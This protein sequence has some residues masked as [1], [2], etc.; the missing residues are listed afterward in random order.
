M[1]NIKTFVFN[2]FQEN[3]YV[4]SDDRNEAV[5]IDCGA[6]FNEE[7][8]ELTDYI[9]KNNL[10][11][12]HLLSTHGHIDHNFG[13]NTIADY[14]NVRPE[15]HKAD[16]G[17]M[18][19]LSEQALAFCNFHLEYDMPEVSDYLND[20]DIIRFGNHEIK[21]IH[22]P[23]HSPGSTVLYI[24]DEDVAFSGDTLFMMSIGRTDLE[25]GSFSDIQKSLLRMIKE[26]PDN[27][28]V[29]PGHGPQTSI[30]KEKLHNPYIR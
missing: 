16:A 22:T 23:G 28:K 25:G 20:G 19:R 7:R 26:L 10:K 8:K 21:V 14:Y 13:N 11:V 3:T 12:V 6:F 27:T 30:A 5:I 24:A 17:L 9:D 29:F 15:V 2:P 18:R 1:L 4:V